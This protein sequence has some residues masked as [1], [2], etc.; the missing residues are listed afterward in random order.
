LVKL[1]VNLCAAGVVGV[2]IT[3][4]F[5]LRPGTRAFDAALDAASI[6][7]AIFTVASAFTGFATFLRIYNPRLSADPIF[8]QQLGRFL[9]ENP[10][11]QAWLLTVIFGSVLTVLTFAVR[12]WTPT[13]IV[14]VL[15]VATLI[16]LGT[17]G[18]SGE[19]SNH[20]TAVTALIL[21]MVSAAVWLG[22]LILLL[23][24]RPFLSKA[25]IATVVSR[26]SSLA[27]AAFIVVALSGTVRA[28]VTMRDLDGVFTPYGALVI[29]KVAALVGMGV[30]GVVYR[31]RVIPQLH[32]E[33][34][35]RSFWAI[36][37]VEFALMGV[38]SGTAA[39][40]GGTPSPTTDDEPP[41]L[42]PARVLTGSPLPTPLD[43][44]QW[45]AAW[46]FDLLWLTVVGAMLFLYVAGVW[47]LR[48]RG[49]SW[50]IH[51]TI[52]WVAGSL[53][54]FWVTN[55]A[56][57][58]YQDYLFSVHMLGHMLLSMA[59]PV[60]LVSA[61]PITLAMRA[62]RKR[63]DGTRG[64]REWIMWALHTPLSRVLT[65]P[66]V[67]AGL[68]IGSLWAFYYT[69]LFRWSLY[70]HAGHIWM[71]AHFVI[72]GYLFA[73]TLLDGDPVPRRLPYPG[74]L[75]LLI[76]VMAMHAFFGIAIMMNPGLMAAEWFGAMGRQWGAI[77][78]DDQYLGGGIA[79]SVGEIP[80]LVVAIAVAIQWSRSDERQQRRRDRH[81]DRAGDLELA[82]YNE[83][84]ARLA[85]KDG[86]TP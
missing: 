35:A 2:L 64:G 84:L 21:H 82:T 75:L 30:L 19:E 22:G 66:F 5:A 18:H 7:A 70:D 69:D 24:V 61:T 46:R 74:R 45:V 10:I 85:A 33:S 27:L 36:I 77:P 60:L 4:L 13:L 80:T 20:D 12:S 63:D 49:D 41:A 73:L 39:A 23:L 11:G 28:V 52:F 54:L 53:L 1:V 34:G 43:A 55:G 81:V 86:A 62:I 31:R 38:A 29:V 72:T 16:P 67:A 8:G 42:T 58:V 40:L 51:R 48:R 47:R 57:N 14:A 37:L 78:L 17:L 6:S 32:G 59:I 79:W 76:G 71:V 83:E 56:V 65:H 25:E 68:F 3:A 50:P 26:Y 44:F 9:A 15:S